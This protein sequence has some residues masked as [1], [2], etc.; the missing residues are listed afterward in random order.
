MCSTPGFVPFYKT[1]AHLTH[2]LGSINTKPIR[3]K[4]PSDCDLRILC[5]L[6]T[7]NF[8]TRRIKLLKF[9]LQEN[10][11]RSSDYWIIIITKLKKKIFASILNAFS[12]YAMYIAQDVEYNRIV[13]YE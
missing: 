7:E 12:F 5:I 3:S 2:C 13:K 11:I 4:L 1:T 10:L 6:V 9:F 8:V